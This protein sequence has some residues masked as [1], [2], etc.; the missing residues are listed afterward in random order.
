MNQSTGQTGLETLGIGK[1]RPVYVVAEIGATHQGQLDLAE[2]LIEESA[3]CGANAV[4]LQA[5]NPDASYVPESPSHAI[6]KAL[7][8]EKRDLKHLMQV[9][10]DN[11][12][13]LFTTPGSREDLDTAVECGMRLIKISSGLLTHLPLVRDAAA[14]GL[15]LILS[16]GMKY[17]DEV[18]RSVRWAE[19][20][21]CRSMA[22]LHCTSLYP[23]PPSTLNL[24]AMVAMR[25]A[26]TY[27][28][29]YSDHTDGI[30]AA[31]ATTT[32]GSCLI[33]K[34]LTLDRN[35][36]GP[37]DFF[38]ADPVQFSA[39]V[40]AIRDTE[41]M[42]GGAVKEPHPEEK[43]NRDLMHRCLVA[44]RPI[45]AGET[46]EESC[47]AFKRPKPGNPG[48]PTAL[49]HHV[50]GLRA[51]RDIAENENIRFEALTGN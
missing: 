49:L 20:A 7:W 25:E 13:E 14:T 6:F 22:L 3:R 2:K 38:A 24:R 32:L 48:L 8:L 39:M 31:I 18:A 27:P 36:P 41:S 42:M 1:D 33:E 23:A 11:S 16:T 9:A 37:E 4:K 26:F 34:H 10:R 40:R 44:A 12:V 30:Q 21:G 45:R 29:G 51:A 47:L 46:I 5:I 19:E 17:L 50:V 28:V 43:A 35:G 15:P